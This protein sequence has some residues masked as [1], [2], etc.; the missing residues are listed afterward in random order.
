MY[1]PPNTHSGPTTSTET[2]T[3]ALAPS[4][5]SDVTQTDI[6]N[7]LNV[8]L[9]TLEYIDILIVN[10]YMEFEE[11]IEKH[12]QPMSLTSEHQYSEINFESI[13][14]SNISLSNHCFEKLEE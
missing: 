8:I 9:K 13:L 6:F 5:S 2:K 7:S 12:V 1:T 11:K 3:L 10:K 4:T 14:Q